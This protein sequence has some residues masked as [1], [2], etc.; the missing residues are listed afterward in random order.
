[1]ICLKTFEEKNLNSF[2]NDWN[3]WILFINENYKYSLKY[4]FSKDFKGK[5]NP[6]DLPYFHP[7][8]ILISKLRKR[9]YLFQI[10]KWYN[11]CL[12]DKSKVKY[13]FNSS[14]NLVDIENKIEKLK[15]EIYF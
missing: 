4:S 5:C 2:N 7:Y 10:I 12:I 3:K 11:E 8:W 9:K 15:S 6:I 14:T 1:M 13:Y